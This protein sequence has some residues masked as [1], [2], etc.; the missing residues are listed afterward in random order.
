MTD[1]SHLS[2]NERISPHV[3]WLR[4]V[5]SHL[6]AERRTSL[7]N[8]CEQAAD[9]LLA[10]SRH[11][12]TLLAAH[13]ARQ[14]ETTCEI[15]HG[16]ERCDYPDCTCYTRSEKPTEQPAAYKVTDTE[17]MTGLYLTEADAKR[18]VFNIETYRHHKAT[19]RPL[20]QSPVETA[21]TQEPAG[22]TSERCDWTGEGGS[23][24]IYLRGHTAPH[25]S[26]SRAAW[27]AAQCPEKASAPRLEPIH[28]VAGD[29]SSPVIGHREVK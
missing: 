24:C 3:K 29:P 10:V 28:M 22:I 19:M 5:A 23:P 9:E 27:V 12:D 11:R 7:A 1:Q 13:E 4:E 2:S 17:G 16:C 21:A 15:G 6:R 18:A 20:Y 26:E 14:D 8:T 25:C